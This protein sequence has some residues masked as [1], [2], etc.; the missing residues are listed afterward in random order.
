MTLAQNEFS[1]NTK[2]ISL[3]MIFEKKRGQVAFYRLAL[4]PKKLF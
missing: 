1:Q 2:F 3:R 4:L